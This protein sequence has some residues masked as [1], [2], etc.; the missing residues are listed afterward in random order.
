MHRWIAP[1][2][3]HAVDAYGHFCIELLIRRTS[4]SSPKPRRKLFI[5]LLQISAPIILLLYTQS[6][7]KRRESASS[8]SSFAEEKLL[9]TS[10]PNNGLVSL[11][12]SAAAHRTIYG[13]KFGF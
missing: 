12:R 3:S 1:S 8:I 2:T 4:A 7:S 13:S 11:V 5:N 10:G 6:A 9:K